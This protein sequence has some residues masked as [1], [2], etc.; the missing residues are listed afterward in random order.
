MKISWLMK[1]EKPLQLFK[2]KSEKKLYLIRLQITE[3]WVVK[4]SGVQSKGFFHNDSTSIEIDNK[5]IED[6]SELAKQFNSHYIT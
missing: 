3:S 2:R 6:E 1:S 4:S 5:I